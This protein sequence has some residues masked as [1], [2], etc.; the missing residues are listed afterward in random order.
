MEN[1]IGT[2]TRKTKETEIFLKINLD[3]RGEN[4]DRYGNCLFLI[5]Y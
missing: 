2:V 5:I 3:G 1:R 4:H